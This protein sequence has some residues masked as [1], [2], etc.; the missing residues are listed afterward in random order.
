M[1]RDSFMQQLE[2]KLKGELDLTSVREHVQYY[3]SYI[4]DEINNGKSEV[5]VLESLGDPWAIA[6][7]IIQAQGISNGFS[8]A[9]V[10]DEHGDEYTSN[11]GRRTSGIRFHNFGISGWKI[12]FFCMAIFFVIVLAIVI[13]ARIVIA[14]A[15][16]IIIGIIILLAL[17]YFGN[18]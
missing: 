11:Q 6:K 1:T 7:S 15:P 16:V 18:R 4:D 13:F 3:N 14:F 8:G 2:D 5:E 9:T 12:L 10:V 17:R